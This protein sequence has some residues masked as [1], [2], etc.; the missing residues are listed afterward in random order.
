MKQVRVRIAPSPTGNLHLGTAHTA[1]FNYLF[2]N[3]NR[4]SFIL[5]F[6]DTDRARSTLESEKNILEGLKWLGLEWDE[7]P[8]I[9]GKYGPY[10]QMERLDLYKRYT[11]KL[12]EERKAYYCFCDEY[13]LKEEREKQAKRGEAPKY[14]GK[15]RTLN[16]EERK[17]L[18]AEGRKPSVRFKIDPQIVNFNDLIKGKLSF[19]TENFGDPIIVKS[20]GIPIYNLANVVDDKTMSI[21]H[22][23]RGEDI[24]PSTP[25]QVL[26]Y[27]ALGMEKDI[28]QFAHMPLLLN[29]DHSKLSKRYGAVSVNEFKQM[30]YLPEVLINFLGL[31]GWHPK[32]ERELFSKEELIKEFRLEDVQKSPAI[33]N[34][35]KLDSMNGQYIRSLENKKIVQRLKDIMVLPKADEKYIEKV[36][37]LVKGRMKKLT[38]FQELSE[39]FFKEPEY[40]S[41]ILIFKKSDKKKTKQGLASALQILE[42]QKEWPK[43]EE[44]F[45]KLLKKIMGEKNLSFGDVFWPVRAA[46]SGREASPSPTELLW[47]L[48]KEESLRRIKKALDL[49]EG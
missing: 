28:P 10:R 44:E 1:L 23:I 3:K 36:V 18:R 43:T 46:L 34:V 11:D 45:E 48:D 32:D 25:A 22:V 26:L 16:E 27:R 5:R 7:G 38:D 24:L 42:K 31:L 29:P 2:A 21:T 39:Y 8:K 37:N 15:C 4:G 14:S 17:N 9:G 19:N 49:L 13:E 40:D 20:D 30:G 6:E 41:K 12:L 33:F 35:E 47:V